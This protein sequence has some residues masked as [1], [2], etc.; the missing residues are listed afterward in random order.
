LTTIGAGRTSSSHDDYW[1]PAGG[2]GRSAIH[3]HGEYN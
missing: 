3:F 2:G 1:S